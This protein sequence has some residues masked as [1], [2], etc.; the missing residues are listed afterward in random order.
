[1]KISRLEQ[2]DLSVVEDSTIYS[3]DEQSELLQRIDDGNK[4][5]GGLKFVT[6]CYGI[7]GM[8]YLQINY[9]KALKLFLSDLLV[10]FLCSQDS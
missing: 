8:L 5:T 3:Q 4:S 9:F 6:T 2:S 7:V 10:V 1:M